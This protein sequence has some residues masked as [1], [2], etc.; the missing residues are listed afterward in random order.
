ML[1][2]SEVAFVGY[3]CCPHLFSHPACRC[4]S[5]KTIIILTWLSFKIHLKTQVCL[6]FT[7]GK[8]IYCLI[9]VLN[10]DK[11]LSAAWRKAKHVLTS[12]EKPIS[13]AS[14]LLLL[15]CCK[16]F[17]AMEARLKDNQGKRRRGKTKEAIFFYYSETLFLSVKEAERFLLENVSAV[18]WP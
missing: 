14:R 5:D 8:S 10:L 3:R 6:L 9:T 2:S 1:H 15:I 13:L 16:C 4:F 12:F 11:W 18:M 17:V 7:A